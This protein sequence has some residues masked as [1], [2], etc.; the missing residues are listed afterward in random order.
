MPALRRV[1]LAEFLGTLL[2]LAG[3]IGSAIGSMLGLVF[4][5]V[6]NR[7]FVFKRS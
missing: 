4:N 6:G 7:L 2:L 1:L 5:W 3:V